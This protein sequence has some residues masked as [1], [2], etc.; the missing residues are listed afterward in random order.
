[1]PTTPSNNDFLYAIHPTCEMS[2]LLTL[3]KTYHFDF[4]HEEVLIKKFYYDEIPFLIFD[5][6]WN[7]QEFM[8][9]LNDAIPLKQVIAEILFLPRDH[10]KDNA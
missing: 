6:H 10:V 2:E 5:S 8:A 1:M 3:L 4:F 7:R 9:A